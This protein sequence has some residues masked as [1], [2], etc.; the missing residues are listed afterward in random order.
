MSISLSLC[1]ASPFSTPLRTFRTQVSH[2]PFDVN[3]IKINKSV[4]LGFGSGSGTLGEY[5]IPWSVW[6]P[7]ISRWFHEDEARVGWITSSAGQRWAV[8][9]PV[10]DTKSRIRVFDF[11]PYNIYN[12]PDDFPGEVVK[13]G[14]YYFDHD[15]V[16][17]EDIKMGL[18]CIAYTTPETYDFDEVLMEE[19]R[20]LGLKV[21]T[22]YGFASMLSYIDRS[23]MEDKV[24]QLLYSIL[25]DSYIVSGI[26]RVSLRRR[27]PLIYI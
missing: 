18:G 20:L 1:T 12:V 8:L 14:D 2:P 25:A 22:Q 17:A 16:F 6:G 7:P 23:T 13:K 9:D 3:P 24:T 10:D 5:S 19:E 11:N 15:D 4:V 21:G 27:L 26:Y